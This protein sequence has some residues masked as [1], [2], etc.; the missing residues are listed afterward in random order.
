VTVARTYAATLVGVAGHVV[1]FEADLSNGL[2]GITFTGYPTRPWWR[3]VIESA[4]RS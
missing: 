2:P 3:R 1:E 4:R